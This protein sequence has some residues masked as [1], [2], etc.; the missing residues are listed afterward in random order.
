MGW[1][2]A[3]IYFS[4][5]LWSLLQE[6]LTT[7]AY[8][9]DGNPHKFTYHFVLNL[10][11]NLTAALLAGI[12]LVAELVKNAKY[13]EHQAKHHHHH[14]HHPQS[15]GS[16]ATA[17]PN[18]PAQPPKKGTT[19][20]SGAAVVA[21]DAAVVSTK[22]SSSSH[23]HS[24]GGG[25]SSS[26]LLMVLA[27]VGFSQ[28]FASP[29]G[30]AALKY[31]SYP[32]VLTAKMCKMVVVLAAG[33]VFH[34]T[35]YSLV[36]TLDCLCITV[37]VLGFS[38]LEDK[39]SKGVAERSS[40]WYGLV[41]VCI[42]LVMD[43]YTNSTQDV[44]VKVHKFSG[45]KLMC[46]TNVAAAA[47]TLFALIALH[48]GAAVYPGAVESEFTGAWA[49]IASQPEAGWDLVQMGL[50]NGSGQ[51]FVFWAMSMFGSLTVTA[52]TLVRKIGSVLLSIWFHGHVVSF[53]Q[54]C[55]LVLVVVGVV[56]D[57]VLTVHE[58]SKHHHTHHHSSS[59]NVTNGS[60]SG[61]PLTS[62]GTVLPPQP[63][64]VSHG[65]PKQLQGKKQAKKNVAG[66]NADT[67]KGVIV[68]KMSAAKPKLVSQVVKRK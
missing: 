18:L 54:S 29:F 20:E 40:S 42:N 57:T 27:T 23:H 59:D 8:S 41:L 50:L 16:T 64:V 5:G 14:H 15:S 48:V 13:R 36:K 53:E 11:Q 46:L 60:S 58:K 34:G 45:H 9:I 17:Q 6:K 19:K 47:W 65:S 2:V 38:L 56:M 28:A 66:A 62:S 44:M 61:A 55:A 24:S 25:V 12:V 33:A 31:V 43:G 68:A 32:A 21:G 51:F 35:R 10:V 37:G 7:R 49:F 30:Y 26:S 4:F 22:A 63:D 1:C 39:G 67:T 3:G 52:M